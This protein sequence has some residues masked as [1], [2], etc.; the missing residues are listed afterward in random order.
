MSSND[1]IL[2]AFNS[3]TKISNDSTLEFQDKLQGILSEIM[4]C[5]GTGKGSIMLVK[6]SGNLEVEASTNPELIG[7]TQPLEGDS[8]STWV[9]KNRE[10][11][12]MTPSGSKGS[13]FPSRQ[14]RYEKG[15]FLLAPILSEDK[16]IGVISATEKVG[17]DSFTQNEQ[18]AMLNIASH[19]IGA[20]ETHR[21]A[22][23]LEDSRESL[24]KKNAQ[25]KKLEEIRSELFHMLIHDLKGPISEVIANLDILSYTSDD[26]N[27][28]YVESAQSACD[29][30]HR[31]ISNL[32]DIVRLEEGSLKLIDERLEP[33]DL[34]QE[35]VSRLYGL[36]KMKQLDMSMGVPQV[37][38]NFYF[39]GDRQLLLRVLQNLLS[40]AIDYSPEGATIETGYYM[41]D[42]EKVI[43]YV[44]DKGPGIAPE[45]RET[46]FNKYV[47]VMHNVG[48]REHAT[49]LGLAF[50][51][52]AVEAHGGSIYVDDDGE[53][54]SCF[55]FIINPRL[56][57]VS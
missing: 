4:K 1:K 25:L 2:N 30:L 27:I 31:M 53:S 32:L 19:V 24:R 6:E 33:R 55:K 22:R 57:E 37:N 23:S 28:E 48:Q 17:H 54:G 41:D 13:S 39:M 46:I 56:D 11:L 40:N 45:F 44:K 12:Y 35:A 9:V 43:F 52:L 7:I 26:E 49:G 3:V 10:P 14:G 34:I 51:K 47:Q 50:C 18:E 20:L 21:L 36:A 16:V 15:A 38:S 5:M 8:P 42:P 29:T